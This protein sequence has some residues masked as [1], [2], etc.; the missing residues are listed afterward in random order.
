MT[1]WVFLLAITVLFVANT[2][3]Q[4]RIGFRTGAEGGYSVGIFCAVQW[5]MKQDALNVENVSTGET[6]SAAE[7]ASYILEQIRHKDV[8]DADIIEFANKIEDLDKK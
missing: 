6:A 3:I 4:H 1:D 8:K 5:L 7:L 2:I